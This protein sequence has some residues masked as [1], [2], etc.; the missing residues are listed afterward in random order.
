MYGEF[1]FVQPWIAQYLNMTLL[2]LVFFVIASLIAGHRRLREQ[3]EWVMLGITLFVP[4]M[5]LA[6]N[7]MI[8][9]IACSQDFRYVYPAIASFCGL[10]GFALEQH[11]TEKRRIWFA[12]GIAM[13]AVFIFLSLRFAAIVTL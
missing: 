7:R 2:A 8:N 12:A 11:I 5:G 6:A 10:L 9:P 1:G 13:M 3:P 4:I